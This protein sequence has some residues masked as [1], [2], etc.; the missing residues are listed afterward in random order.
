VIQ[1]SRMYNEAKTWNPAVGCNYDCIYCK[2]SF[3]KLRKWLGTI[4]DCEQCRNYEPHIH[5]NNFFNVP[6]AKI[7]FAFG[8]G[9][10]TFYNPDYI[11]ACILQLANHLYNYPDTT[12]LFQTKNPKIYEKYLKQFNLIKE[13]TV[14]GITLETNRFKGYERF[15]KAPNPRTR[16]KDFI[17][18]KWPRKWVTIEPIMDFDMSIFVKWIKAIGP[19]KVYM[20]YN[21]RK[22][23]QLPEPDLRKF[24]SLKRTL[25]KFTTVE[26]KFIPNK[27]INK[28]K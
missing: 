4:Y 16:V 28:N 11:S 6:V 24:Y 21:S 25:E 14:L 18:I 27:K 13:N 2:P 10:I 7:I 1:K 8:N 5:T 3:Q 17:A 19:E 15:S 22:R 23:P 26:L 9:D 20:G 12:I